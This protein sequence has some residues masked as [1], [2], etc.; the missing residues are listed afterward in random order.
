MSA[1]PRSVRIRN[2]NKQL[3][4]EQALAH[5]TAPCADPNCK[6]QRRKHSITTGDHIH[7]V[8]TTVC[9]VDGCDCQQFVEADK[10]P[11]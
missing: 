2:R 4:E 10:C 5:D 9:S 6:H 11:F 8:R 1:I 3:G 7:G